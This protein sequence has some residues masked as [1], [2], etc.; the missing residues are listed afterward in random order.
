MNKKSNGKLQRHALPKD[1]NQALEV[2]ARKQAQLDSLTPEQREKREDRD[3]WDK[4]QLK[5]EGE[6][7]RDDEKRLKKMA[8]R[9]ERQKSK[10]AKLWNERKETVAS[11]IAAKVAKRNLN[12][13]ARA[14]AAKDKKAGI[15]N[16]DAGKGKH[17]TKS[18]SHAS[19]V[20]GAGGTGAGSKK[21]GGRP[22]FEGK[23]G[24]KK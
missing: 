4:V 22:G 17:K 14:K 23:G 6:K 24:K 13:A 12:L 3:R 16:K 18:K 15:K 1:P 8:K 5:A 10:S 9:Q 11:G 19:R 7:I 21:G 2:L 20:K